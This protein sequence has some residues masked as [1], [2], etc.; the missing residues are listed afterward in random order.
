MSV[1]SHPA[2]GQDARQPANPPRPAA[3]DHPTHTGVLTSFPPPVHGS[4]P[5]RR[6]PDYLRTADHGAELLGKPRKALPPALGADDAPPPP[7]PPRR[8]PPCP[9]APTRTGDVGLTLPPVRRHRPH[10]ATEAH[11]SRQGKELLGEPPATVPPV[12]GAETAEGR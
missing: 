6:L 5:D 10:P 3:A 1:P 4:R 8:T 2:T 12:L 9:A 7:R 11:R